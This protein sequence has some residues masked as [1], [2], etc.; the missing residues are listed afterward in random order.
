MSPLLK[1]IWIRQYMPDVFK[2]AHKFLG[3]KEY[4]WFRLSGK[5]ESD[6]SCASATGLM[7]L[8]DNS[9]DELALRFAGI[10]VEQL[11]S[12]VLPAHCV[13]STISDLPPLMIGA[14]D[15]ALANLGC[16]ATKTGQYAITIGTSAA[17]RC[18]TSDP[19]LDPQMRTFCYRLDSGHFIVGGASNNGAN[20]L[21]W[22]RTSVFQSKLTPDDFA[23]QAKL[24]PA[25]AEGLRFIPY[26][27]VER[28]P[29]WNAF[30]KASFEG[31]T[32]R[33]T[34]AHFVRAVMEGVLLNLK[35]IA[36][37]LEEHIPINSIQTSGGFSKNQHWV[38]ML[39]ELLDKPVIVNSL[40]VDASAYG[41][42]LYAKANL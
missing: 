24:V 30:A 16:G 29:V 2:N 8:L 31:I 10:N 41:A 12:L 33:H 4:V 20:T 40:G 13:F 15:G 1:L 3:I 22:L 25:G 38:E 27:Y 34:Q 18:V 11:P 36:V 42:F 6:I 19:I 39:S 26:L 28:A 7:N 32:G 35:A 23:N 9:W 37:V 14:S 21:E 5:F 17:I